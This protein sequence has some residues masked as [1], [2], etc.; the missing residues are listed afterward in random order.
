MKTL[1]RICYIF[2]AIVLSIPSLV[3][4]NSGI[5][6]A[7]VGKK[8]HFQ[9]EEITGETKID[10]INNAGKVLYS[11]R[12]VDVKHYAKKFDMTHL[13]EGAYYVRVEDVSKLK[14]YSL[15]LEN[16]KLSIITVDEKV[17]PFF[18]KKGKKLYV[19]LLNLESAE[20]EIKVIDSNNRILFVE[21][22]DSSQVVEKAINFEKAYDDLYTV[23][24]TVEGDTF[25]E[26]VVIK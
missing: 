4:A 12:L 2:T 17:K 15:L 1:K 24:V 16:D 7:P 14:T 23:I 21:R 26:N 11:E 6:L 25:S 9:I 18:W 19:N 8:M 10:F 20:V 5:I 13:V 3:M 22:I